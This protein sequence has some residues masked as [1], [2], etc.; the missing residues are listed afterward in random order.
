MWPTT[1]SRWRCKH[2]RNSLTI[3]RDVSWRRVGWLFFATFRAAFLHMRPNL[4]RRRPGAASPSKATNW[5]GG[6]PH[7]MTRISFSAI[8]VMLAHCAGFRLAASSAGFRLPGLERVTS[9]IDVT[10]L[11][12][13]IC[14]F[15][16]MCRICSIVTVASVSGTV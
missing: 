14:Q 1:A 2:A 4:D 3:N 6:T 10:R 15:N 8:K 13:F 9:G 11:P 5:K 16:I 12:K 7:Q